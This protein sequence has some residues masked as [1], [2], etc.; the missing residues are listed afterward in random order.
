[1]RGRRK[2]TGWYDYWTDAYYEGG[3]WIRADAPLEKIP[4]FVREGAVLPLGEAAL[5]TQELS[6]ALQVK[7]YPGRDGEFLLYED[8]GEDYGYEKGQYRLTRLIWR[9]QERRLESRVTEPMATA[10]AARPQKADQSP[11]SPMWEPYR[12]VSVVEAKRP[13]G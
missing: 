9:D 4:L 6:P 3:Q 1:M 13:Q 2:A 5:S 12:I 11:A 10:S 7:V 8:Q